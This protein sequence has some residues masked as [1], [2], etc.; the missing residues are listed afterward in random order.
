MEEPVQQE[1]AKAG[2]LVPHCEK[3]PAADEPKAHAALAPIGNKEDQKDVDSMP[4]TLALAQPTSSE[5]TSSEL[6]RAKGANK[7]S[8]PADDGEIATAVPV[9]SS[10]EK[11]PKGKSESPT[12]KSQ[13][14]KNDPAASQENVGCKRSLLEQCRDREASSKKLRSKETEASSPPA[15]AIVSTETVQTPEKKS[16]PDNKRRGT[17]D[18]CNRPRGEEQR[19][20]A[21]PKCLLAL[22]NLAGHQSLQKCRSDSA[23][24]ASVR[25]ASLE[26]SREYREKDSDNVEDGTV[27]QR[28]HRIECKMDKIMQHLGLK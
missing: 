26:E 22:R 15:G 6:C 7:F 23:L 17:C 21:C 3:M 8:F 25:E 27:R 2:S 18:I 20:A 9:S 12:V 4:S 14:P 5:P 11:E 24:L 16:P 10:Q 1:C 19:G 13:L 28:L